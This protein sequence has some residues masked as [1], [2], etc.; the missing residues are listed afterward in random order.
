MSTLTTEAFTLMRLGSLVIL[1]RTFLRA[2]QAGTRHLRADDYL[3]LATLPTYIAGTVVVYVVGVTYKGLANSSMT[4]LERASLNP[5]SEEYRLR[6]A[7]SK[8][9]VGGWCLYTTLLWLIKA[10]LCS[11]YQQLTVREH[12]FCRKSK[13]CSVHNGGP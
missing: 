4:Y 10:S 3:M 8:I 1:L 9:Q 2:R 13:S 5:N 7:G 6:V 11:F 12:N